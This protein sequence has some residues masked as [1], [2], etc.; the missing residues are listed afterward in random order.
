MCSCL[1]A[2]NELEVT[3]E[4]EVDGEDLGEVAQDA[5]PIV[6]DEINQDAEPMVAR[7]R[8]RKRTPN[9]KEQRK[10][11]RNRGK[12]YVTSKG[13]QISEKIFSNPPCSCK[14]KCS[15]NVTEEQRM[16][17]FNHFYGMGSFQIQ[18]AY[19]CG[20]CKQCTPK[21]RR[22]R[23]GSR[24]MKSTSISYHL[25]LVDKNL[26]VCKQYFLKT[27]QISDGR[28]FRALKKVRVG[29]EP[30]SDLRGKQPSVNKVDDARLQIVR[31]H[32]ESFP[33]YQSHYTRAHNPN[34]KFLSEFLNIRALYNLYKDHCDNI[35]A[36]AVS[37][38]KYR[39][40]FNYEYNLHFHAPHKD[41]C[42][43][44]DN[45]KIKIAG[46]EDPQKL[47]ELENSKELHLRKAQLAR[48]KLV[49]AKA[50]S[51]KDDSNVYGLTFDLQ[52]ALAFP[53][54][55]CSIAYYKRNM[56][57]YNMGCHELSSESAYM[58][59]WD[60][61]VASRG[62]QEIASCLLEHFRNKVPQDK[63]HVVMFSDSCGGQN[64]NIKLA[65]RCMQFLQ[66]ENTHLKTIDQKFMTS[67]HSFLP[68]DADFGVIETYSKG[69]IMNV[70]RDWY[71]AITKSRRKKPYC[72]KVMERDE[73]MSTKNLE[74]AITRRKKNTEGGKVSWH[75]IQ[76]LRYLKEEP[77]KIFYKETL[78]DDMQFFAIDITPA[79]R[80]RRLA[81]LGLVAI[82]PLYPGP[83]PVTAA[84]K[85]DMMD[86]LPYIPPINH[87]FFTALTDSA[88]VDDV[89]IID[90]NS[91][92]ESDRE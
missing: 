83:R 62:S 76:W 90:R 44:C 53:T 54:L 42:T 16:N 73:I 79:R 50:D 67:G 43:K 51:K 1:F 23:D 14:L 49:L 56:Y 9:K 77:F 38:S 47:Q 3:N 89:P 7:T 37:E 60:E 20:L 91:E 26:K 84:K 88:S 11:K 64:R 12:S 10:F 22:V 48:E 27:F 59:A 13:K 35:N 87:E 36:V 70:P 33:A 58:Y 61:T 41:T 82:E 31:D 4:E 24:G 39:H 21:A 72:L 2:D 5:E 55:T 66:N 75:K 52:K 46:C 25:Q 85:R 71:D 69:R 74:K 8:K 92:S 29:C 6:A 28:C 81:H 18:N 40:I 86:L 15:D 30:G 45:L 57:V 68:N 19:L 32:I 80:G 65:L 17:L 63:D 78:N 34:R